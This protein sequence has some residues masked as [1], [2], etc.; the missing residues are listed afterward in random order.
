MPDSVFFSSARKS[1]TCSSVRERAFLC[2]WRVGQRSFS[3]KFLNNLLNGHFTPLK[4]W[5]IYPGCRCG[6]FDWY[7]RLVFAGFGL[8]MGRFFVFHGQGVPRFAVARI[9]SEVMEKG[10][11]RFVLVRVGW[12]RSKRLSINQSRRQAVGS[13]HAVCHP[14]GSGCLHQYGCRGW[15]VGIFTVQSCACF[16]CCNFS[17]VFVSFCHDTAAVLPNHCFHVSYADCRVGFCRS[18]PL[19]CQYVF[20]CHGEWS[21]TLFIGIVMSHLLFSFQKISKIHQISQGG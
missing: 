16:S 6:G 14:C 1:P 12:C 18:A 2:G 19:L 17:F 8:A 15:V 11:G 20:R 13:S 3:G 4:Q 7:M 5:L 21:H 9:G 10:G